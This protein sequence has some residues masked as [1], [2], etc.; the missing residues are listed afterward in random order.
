MNGQSPS[1]HRWRSTTSPLREEAS[2]GRSPRK[3]APLTG[4]LAEPARAEGL[5]PFA[6]C[7]TFPCCKIRLDEAVAAVE[8]GTIPNCIF[9]EEL[10][11]VKKFV[12]G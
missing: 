2:R 11:M 6:Q 5:C 12:T 8:Q 7:R 9:P 4:E 10:G 1:G 3:K